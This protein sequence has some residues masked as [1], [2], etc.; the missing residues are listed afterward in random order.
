MAAQQLSYADRLAVRPLIVSRCTAIVN[1]LADYH[2]NNSGST[3]N[4][5]AWA[6]NAILN[7]GAVGEQVSWHVVSRDEF[8]DNGS[9]IDANTLKTIVETAINDHFIEP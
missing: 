8:L 9:S 1:F 7:A 4:Q 5:K 3:A 2:I 6:S